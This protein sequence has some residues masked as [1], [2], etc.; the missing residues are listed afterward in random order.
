MKIG[1]VVAPVQATK[2]CQNM[3]GHTL[4]VVKS[5]GHTF[6]A[7]DLVGATVGDVVLCSTR[8][9]QGNPLLDTAIIAVVDQ[10]EEDYDH[11]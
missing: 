6:V 5:N 8:R 7:D 4:L 11:Q 1:L 3:A 9:E 2:T 10:K